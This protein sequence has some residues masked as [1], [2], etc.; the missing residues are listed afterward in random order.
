MP[1]ASS[2]GAAQPCQD[3]V[4]AV[5]VPSEADWDL[6]FGAVLLRLQ[7]CA[8]DATDAH[9][10]AVVLDCVHALALL[11]A[12][13]LLQRG[14]QGQGREGVAERAVREMLLVEAMNG[15]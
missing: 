11:H 5:C 12:G 7:Q 6:M 14:L 1:T 8:A 2:S 10:G 15:P 4:G 13:L 9:A 3:G